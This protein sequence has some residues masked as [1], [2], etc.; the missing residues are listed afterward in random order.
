MDA[1]TAAPVDSSSRDG[2]APH[3]AP[4]SS[5]LFAAVA[6]RQGH[7]RPHGRR[8]DGR[9]H[10]CSCGCRRSSR[11]SGRSPSGTASSSVRG[12]SIGFQQLLGRSSRSST[13]SSSRR[14]ST[15]SSC[16]CSCRCAAWSACCSPTCSTRTSAARRIYQSI[17]YMPV[18]LSLA[19]VGFIWKSVM[20][21][22]E[23]G[24]VQRGARPHG[25]GQPDRLGRQRREDLQIHIPFLDTPLGLTKNFAALLIA[26]AWRH[27]GYVMVLYL[28]GLKSVDPSLREAAA[29][30]GCNEW[31]GVPSGDLPGDEADQ[32]RGVRHHRHR[33]AACVRHHRRAEGAARH[34]G[35][36]RARARQP[37]R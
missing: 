14:C 32:R 8:A 23:P 16:S 34:E 36:R 20:W 11:S 13:A 25:P 7:A 28:A 21:S 17:F 1:V 5:A 29:I 37:R 18:V 35:A 15:T 24:P 10:R 3:G 4:P 33:G 6:Q 9:P 31:H 22:P 2:G 26:M 27:I 12:S 30:D 19:V